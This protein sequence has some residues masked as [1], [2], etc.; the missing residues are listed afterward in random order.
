MASGKYTLNI[1][2][3]SHYEVVF[4]FYEDDSITPLSFNGYEAIFVARERN[5]PQSKILFIP[6][7]LLISENNVI[8]KVNAETSKQVVPEVGYFNLILKNQTSKT[9]IIEGDIKLTRS[10][11]EN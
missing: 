1:D 5:S 2:K 11:D 8:L 7:E 10:I 4:S 9:R 3:N 6:D